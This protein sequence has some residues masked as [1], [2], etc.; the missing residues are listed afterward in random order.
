MAKTPQETV[1]LAV[2]WMTPTGF[3]QALEKEY[4]RKDGIRVP[5]LIGGETFK[6]RNDEG[7]AFVVDL[8]RQK[9]AEE[10]LQKKQMSW[11]RWHA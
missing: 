3:F 7:V 2:A 8:S 9:R 10:A 5:V 4:F 6:G 11:L 1:I